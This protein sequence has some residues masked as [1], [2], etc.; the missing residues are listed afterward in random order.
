[1]ASADFPA[2]TIPS[3]LL[4]LLH[5]EAFKNVAFLNVVELLD[6]HTAFVTGRD[7]LDRVLEALQGA[8]LALMDD[9]IVAQNADRR[10]ARDLAVLDV[11]AR[12]GAD[13]GDLIGLTDL[14]VTNDGLAEL[15]RR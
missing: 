2:L 5:N 13:G 3:L 6:R 7:L 11:A 15:G 8:E 9:D 12:D 10:V 4:D 14:G 1:M